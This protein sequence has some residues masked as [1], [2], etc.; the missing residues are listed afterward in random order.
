MQKR[1]YKIVNAKNIFLKCRF[2]IK[3]SLQ[4]ISIV[5]PGNIMDKFRCS[6][7]RGVNQIF[8]FPFKRIPGLFFPLA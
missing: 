2:F 8:D 3:F 1:R 6:S 4:M 5:F 7:F